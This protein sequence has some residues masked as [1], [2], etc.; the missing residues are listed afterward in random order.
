[1]KANCFTVKEFSGENTKELFAILEQE[2]IKIHEEDFQ[3][4]MNIGKNG[5]SLIKDQMGILTH[6]NAGALATT[7]IGTAT[8]PMYLA[9]QKGKK[10]M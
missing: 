8:A 7:G 6:C 4:C 10:F 3:L 5:L 1:M 2:A 9:H